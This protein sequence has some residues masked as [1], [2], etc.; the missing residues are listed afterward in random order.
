[1]PRV[2]ARHRGNGAAARDAVPGL[3]REGRSRKTGPKSPRHQPKANRAGK[4]R[5][6][7]FPTRNRNGTAVSG[8][9]RG[10]MA[11]AASPPG[12]RISMSAGMPSP[13][14]SRRIIVIDCA[15]LRFRTSATR[16]CADIGF[17]IASREALLLH[18][19]ADRLDGIRRIDRVVLRLV[20]LD[21]CRQHVDTIIV[22]VCADPFDPDDGSSEIDRDGHSKVSHSEETLRTQEERE[23]AASG[24]FTMRSM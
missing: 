1:M 22:A 4:T 20:N 6:S 8:Y 9:S 19:E 3:R 12:A 24:S 5:P 15:R 7:R 13:S 23:S 14:C 17:K 11:Q 2:T 10:G 16:A 18:A 21:Q